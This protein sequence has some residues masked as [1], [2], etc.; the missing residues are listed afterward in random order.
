MFSIIQT[1]A[2]ALITCEC[3]EVLSLS[4]NGDEEVCDCGRIYCLRVTIVDATLGG[5]G[6]ETV[7]AS[8]C[9]YE[10]G[11]EARQAGRP[12]SLSPYDFGTPE[13]EDWCHGWI[14]EDKAMKILV[15]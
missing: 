12:I 3:G 13:C 4:S 9:W 6:I 1:H 15:K 10:E 5:D 8:S 11:A 2:Q 7:A 14:D